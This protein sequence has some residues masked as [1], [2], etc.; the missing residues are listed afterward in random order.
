MSGVNDLIHPSV[1][2]TI[3]DSGPWNSSRTSRTRA[4][5]EPLVDVHDPLGRARSSDIFTATFQYSTIVG[6]GL[7]IL[8]NSANHSTGSTNFYQHLL[9]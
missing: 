4:S 8:T 2:T 7:R 3:T 9:V 6:A 1:G 5:F